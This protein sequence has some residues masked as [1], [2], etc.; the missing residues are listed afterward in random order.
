MPALCVFLMHGLVKEKLC[1]A[2]GVNQ[3]DVLQVPSATLGTLGS[4]ETS[5]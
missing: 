1:V 3:W 4:C 2:L 5:S